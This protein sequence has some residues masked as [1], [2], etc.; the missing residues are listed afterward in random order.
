MTKTRLRFILMCAQEEY[1]KENTWE[2]KNISI[3]VITS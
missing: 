3:Y 2:S 1:L